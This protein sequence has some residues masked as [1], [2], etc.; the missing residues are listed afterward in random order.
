M[1][2][3]IIRNLKATMK[4]THNKIAR[5]TTPRIGCER[6]TYNIISYSYQ[7]MLGGSL[8]TTAW[9]VLRKHPPGME[10]SCEYIE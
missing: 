7:P 10:G 6:N 5:G 9:R 4:L 2:E 1:A 8:V 3:T